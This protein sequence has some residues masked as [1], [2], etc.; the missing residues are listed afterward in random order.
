MFPSNPIN[1]FK[2]LVTFNS[3]QL[4]PLVIHMSSTMIHFCYEYFKS[5][6]GL[7]MERSSLAYSLVWMPLK[8]TPEKKAICRNSWKWIS[9]RFP[10][11]IFIAYIVY[12]PPPPLHQSRRTEF[13]I[14]QFVKVVTNQPKEIR[15]QQRWEMCLQLE[16]PSSH[17]SPDMS[18]ALIQLTIQNIL[19]NLESITLNLMSGPF[20]R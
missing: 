16:H 8:A 11:P 5:E 7:Q 20:Q 17:V 10:I 6:R 1:L 19:R 2:C 15:F 12:P 9:S 14:S 4:F 18:A 13:L 3:R